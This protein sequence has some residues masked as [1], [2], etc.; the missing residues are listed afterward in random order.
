MYLESVQVLK[1]SKFKLSVQ[2][3]HTTPK[4]RRRQFSEIS[5]DPLRDWPIAQ[6]CEYMFDSFFSSWTELR[7]ERLYFINYLFKSSEIFNCNTQSNTQNNV[8]LISVELF[9]RLTSSS[10]NVRLKDEIVWF[11]WLEN[12]REDKA[13]NFLKICYYYVLDM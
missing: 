12:C 7:R 5:V 3:K 4:I 2:S 10:S 8:K 11:F 1:F 13:W 9:N 6:L